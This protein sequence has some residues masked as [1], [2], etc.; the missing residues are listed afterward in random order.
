M[1]PPQPSR[2]QKKFPTLPGVESQSSERSSRRSHG[3]HLHP[4]RA[5][6]KNNDAAK[7]LSL[8]L[9][10]GHAGKPIRILVKRHIG[11]VVEDSR[12]Q[13]IARLYRLTAPV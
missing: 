8:G 9:V 3:A 11:A 2:M 4:R 12:L 10:S 1:G 6:V 5:T 13:K 7:Y